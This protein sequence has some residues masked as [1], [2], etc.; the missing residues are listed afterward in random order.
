MIFSS[1]RALHLKTLN[2]KWV[3]KTSWLKNILILS[4]QKYFRYFVFFIEPSEWRYYKNGLLKHCISLFICLYP[5]R[6]DGEKGT[7][8]ASVF[9]FRA[10]FL[11]LR[12][13]IWKSF[14]LIC[15]LISR[16]PSSWF[17]IIRS[18]TRRGDLRF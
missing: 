3:R 18:Q 5:N 15:T 13:P 16:F 7:R 4:N 10:L 11:F 17:G 8:S 2:K 12:V 14:A 1:Y 6:K 9:L